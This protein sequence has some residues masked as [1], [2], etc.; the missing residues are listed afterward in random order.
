MTIRELIL[1]LANYHWPGN[2]KFPSG[3]EAEVMMD[4]GRSHSITEAGWVGEHEYNEGASSSPIIRAGKLPGGFFNSE[5]D[6]PHRRML[7]LR[8]LRR[9]VDNEMEKC[10]VEGVLEEIR[11]G[12]LKV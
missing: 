10:Q 2:K 12:R 5:W 9:L 1:E 7:A 6:N 4:D 11:L 8:A 3:F